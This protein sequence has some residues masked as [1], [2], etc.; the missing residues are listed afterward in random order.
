MKVCR[1]LS[2]GMDLH[3]RV[4]VKM[5]SSKSEINSSR[6]IAGLSDEASVRGEPCCP[7]D[8]R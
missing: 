8:E 6:R 4:S 5:A 1:N 3:E 2:L 7:Y